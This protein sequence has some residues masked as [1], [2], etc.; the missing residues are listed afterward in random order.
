MKA[1]ILKMIQI[2]IIDFGG[3]KVSGV[4]EAN[5]QREQEHMQGTALYMAPEYFLGDTVSYQSDQFSLAVIAYHMLSGRFPYG[6]QVAKA[7]TV[8]AQKKLKYHSVLDD[9]REIPAWVDFA[10]RKALHPLPHKR[11]TE[12]SEFLFDLRHP[13]PKFISQERA[14]LIER[15][16][17]LFWKGLSLVLFT[18][19]LC[20]LF[21]LQRLST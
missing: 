13:N 8:S 7:R 12:L 3:V 18:I 11:Y 9:E 6:T 4:V 2:K 5:T 20:L 16:P 1:L 14:P 21:Y 17:L 15:H 10:L 19:V